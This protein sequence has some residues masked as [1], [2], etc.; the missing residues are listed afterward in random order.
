MVGC[1]R[2]ALLHTTPLYVSRLL[3]ATALVAALY[4]AQD[5][6][7][8]SCRNSAVKH[9][10]SM[11]CGLGFCSPTCDPRMAC[12]AQTVVVCAGIVHLSIRYD[13]L[14][15]NHLL[16]LCHCFDVYAAYTS[17]GLLLTTTLP[18]STAGAACLRGQSP[19]CHWYPVGK[20][21]R[22]TVISNYYIYTYA[23]KFFHIAMKHGELPLVSINPLEYGQ[24][25][26]VALFSGHG[27]P[28]RTCCF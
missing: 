23:A 28:S 10:R 6:I 20:S 9:A 2:A 14:V 24:T 27:L 12:C 17:A 26:T 5:I 7:I 16:S 1:T 15:L 22:L 8:Y 25:G 21:N 4:G 11:M 13:V 18:K 3:Y 19:A